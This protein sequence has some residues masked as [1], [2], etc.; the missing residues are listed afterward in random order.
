MIA[1]SRATPQSGDALTYGGETVY[2]HGF[3]LSKELETKKTQIEES[4]DYHIGLSSNW[5]G[6]YVKLLIE[7][8]R[9]YLTEFFILADPRQ[10]KD[11]VQVVPLGKPRLFAEWF[12]GELLRYYGRNL[13][14]TE[15]KGTVLRYKFDKGILTGTQEEVLRDNDSNRSQDIQRPPRL[16]EEFRAA[17]LNEL[18]SRAVRETQ[19]EQTGAGQPATR[20]LV[21]PEGGDKPQPEAE[22]RPR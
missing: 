19:A 1:L 2:V 15:Q 4:R 13:G 3:K 9:L 20:P 5:D 6:F 21:E 22:G 17:K 8:N 14:Y 11:G 18:M 7:D 10:F 16:S 12:S